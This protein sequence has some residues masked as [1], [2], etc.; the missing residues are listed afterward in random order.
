[1]ELLRSSPTALLF[2]CFLGPLSTGLVKVGEDDIGVDPFVV[3]NRCQ[4]LASRA[5]SRK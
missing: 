2:L 4:F 3:N 5:G 1:M